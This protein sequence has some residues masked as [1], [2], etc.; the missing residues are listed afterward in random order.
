M[1][2]GTSRRRGPERDR[3]RVARRQ[4]ER[5]ERKAA[6]RQMV[7]PWFLEALAAGQPGRAAT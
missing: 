3:F 6:G 4:K 1:P 7:F 2:N 5:A